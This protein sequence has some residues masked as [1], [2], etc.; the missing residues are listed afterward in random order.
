MTLRAHA[1]AAID[2]G[3]VVFPIAPGTANKP[4]VTFST[5]AATSWDEA[6]RWWR[7]DDSTN[8]IDCCDDQTCDCVAANE[9]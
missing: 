5:V 2:N 7:R 8:N 9:L 3:F 4:K 1:H 6:K